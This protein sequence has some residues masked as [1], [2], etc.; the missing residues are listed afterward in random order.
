M[1][2][3]LQDNNSLI[4]TVQDG[5]VDNVTWYQNGTVIG[6]DD[7]RF[8]QR[9]AIL[10][11]TIASTEVLLIGNATANFVGS[12]VCEIRDGNGRI[13][14]ATHVFNGKVNNYCK[15]SSI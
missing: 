1:I 13:S 15:L 2:E 3:Y 11:R 7:D 5:L 9:M 14:K 10:D 8:T 6:S 12:F 4:C